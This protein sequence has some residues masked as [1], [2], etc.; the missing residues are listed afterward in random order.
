MNN[1]TNPIMNNISLIS[2]HHFIIDWWNT[3]I[4]YIKSM[5]WS[6]YQY[7]IKQLLRMNWIAIFIGIFS[8]LWTGIIIYINSINWVYY[9]NELIQEIITF[10]QF[11]IPYLTYIGTGIIGF[12]IIG[13]LTYIN[14]KRN[15]QNSTDREFTDED[16]HD[17]FLIIEDSEDGSLIDKNGFILSNDNK[18]FIEKILINMIKKKEKWQKKYKN[19]K[20]TLEKRYCLLK[21][22]F[23]KM[24]RNYY[25]SI[26]SNSKLNIIIKEIR[27]IVESSEYTDP[28]DLGYTDAYN[29]NLTLLKDRAKELGMKHLSHYKWVSRKAL[30]QSIRSREQVHLIAVALGIED[31]TVQEDSTD[32]QST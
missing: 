2:I 10:Q 13:I 8:G 27:E 25:Q 32:D 6:Y 20:K 26:N 31:P 16:S 7:S 21:K 23:N 22:E 18:K 28:N 17:R 5:D 4:N 24:N 15:R 11:I 9:K 14:N 3:F 30:A 19:M 12:I 1:Q 29:W